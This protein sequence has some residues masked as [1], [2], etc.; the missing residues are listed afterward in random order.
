M[1]ETQRERAEL[2]REGLLKI[3]EQV[4]KVKELWVR[5]FSPPPE[6]WDVLK[7]TKSRHPLFE[8]ATPPTPD[9]VKSLTTLA[10]FCLTLSGMEACSVQRTSFPSPN[11]M[12]LSTIKAFHSEN[13]SARKYVLIPHGE[14]RKWAE[15]AEL[16][17]YTLVPIK[18]SSKEWMVP[19]TAALE[20]YGR[21]LAAFAFTFPN[22]SF[23]FPRDFPRFCETLHSLN[24]LLV[25][26]ARYSQSLLG[27]INSQ[28][29]GLDLLLWD[30]STF[31]GD[32][33]PPS[34]S[35][36]IYLAR[37]SLAK[38]LPAPLL[39]RREMESIWETP[40]NHL[41]ATLF[42][43]GLPYREAE[44]LLLILETIGID[45]L[46]EKSGE[47]TL[48]RR[49]LR[50]QLEDTGKEATESTTYFEPLPA[51]SIPLDGTTHSANLAKRRYAPYDFF[52]KVRGNESLDRLHAF[53]AQ[54]KPPKT[55]VVLAQRKSELETQSMEKNAGGGVLFPELNFS[56]REE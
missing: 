46:R 34:Q 5:V 45:G 16:A 9:N 36:G 14:S 7:V 15:S 12:L 50:E 32:R 13:G 17:G 24:I 53:L 35:L 52:A 29:L 3:N 30:E 18:L 22:P 8:S 40:P 37:S 6:I 56:S 55:Q 20:K 44:A 47:L 28:N 25:V 48:R 54:A 23:G 33:F 2:L 19:I 43:Y 11:R 1:I 26:D 21:D 10:D 41:S 31:S 51:E 39:C 38:H 27:Q 4:L 42:P 49:F